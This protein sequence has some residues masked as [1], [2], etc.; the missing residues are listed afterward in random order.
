MFTVVFCLR[1]RADLSEEAF[2]RYWREEH[3]PKVQARAD[4]LRIARYAQLPRLDLPWLA[5]AAAARGA[6]EG[7]DGVAQVSWTSLD[8]LRAT[9]EDPEARRAGREL[10]EDEARFIDFANS[11]IF[12]T[13][14]TVLVGR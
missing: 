1:R 12:F 7:Y 2:R 9:F 4:V 14:E 5:A 11:P 6:P 3:G 10:I 13:E 8:D